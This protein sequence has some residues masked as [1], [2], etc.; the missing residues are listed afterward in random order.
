VAAGAH[1]RTVA[2][3]FPAADG[4]WA[5]EVPLA[6]SY[7]LRALQVL[8]DGTHGAASPLVAVGLA[9]ALRASTPRRV[10]A[11]RTIPVRGSISP[12]QRS[13]T[14]SLWSQGR[15]GRFHYVR[16]AEIRAGRS[17]RFAGRLPVGRAG[18]Y[19]VRVRFAGS[20][21]ARPSAA[22]DR[23]LRAVRDPRKLSGGTAGTGG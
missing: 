19:R 17:G 8:P 4:S 13:V 23:Y 12:A 16:R 22:P 11:G 15:G 1:Y 7:A 2:R 20:R 10:L 21:F 5:A 14:A 6:R 9:P 18:V 3:T